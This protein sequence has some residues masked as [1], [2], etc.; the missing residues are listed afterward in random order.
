[1]AKLDERMEI[2]NTR[3]DFLEENDPN[4]TELENLYDR[5]WELQDERDSLEYTYDSLVDNMSVYA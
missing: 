1:M 2:V 3:I 5:I 4:S